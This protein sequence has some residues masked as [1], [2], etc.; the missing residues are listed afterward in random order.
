MIGKIKKLNW[1]GFTIVMLLAIAGA[2]SNKNVKN[3]YEWGM[4]VL[5][6]GLPIAIL[7]MWLGRQP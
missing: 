5:F 2:A 4:L 1:F 3:I 7:F 6:V